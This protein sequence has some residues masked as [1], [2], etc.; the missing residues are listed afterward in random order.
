MF[1]SSV[2][3]AIVNVTDEPPL[4]AGEDEYAE[5][6]SELESSEAAEEVEGGDEVE[7][8]NMEEGEVRLLP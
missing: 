5:D 6:T 4:D 3:L 1:S 8:E 2:H 7:A